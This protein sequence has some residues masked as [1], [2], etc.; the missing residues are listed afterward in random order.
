MLEAV[1]EAWTERREAV[2]QNAVGLAANMANAQLSSA[3]RLDGPPEVLDA[4]LLSDAVGLL[5]RS[6]DPDAG[7]FGTARSSRRRRFLSS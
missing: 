4:Q 5:A 7:G 2:E 1:H 3:V 6:E